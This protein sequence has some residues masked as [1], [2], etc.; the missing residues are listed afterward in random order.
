VGLTILML[1]HHMKHNIGKTSNSVLAQGQVT[2]SFRCWT[3]NCNADKRFTPQSQ[4]KIYLTSVNLQVC[5]F[6][7][8]FL[9]LNIGNLCKRW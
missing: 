1:F 4:Y 7:F 6:N 2:V 9:K 8:E 5:M 3:N